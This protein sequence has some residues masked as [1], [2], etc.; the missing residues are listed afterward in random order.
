MKSAVIAMVLL[1]ASYPAAGSYTASLAAAA[2]SVLGKGADF[3]HALVDLNRDSHP[4]AIVLA[5]GPKWCGSGGCVMLIFKGTPRG[6]VLV[7][8][9]TITAPPISLLPSSHL[10]WTDLIVHSNGTGDVVLRFDGS[11]YPHNPSLA[12]AATPQQKRS[13]VEILSQAS[14]QHV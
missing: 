6:Y 10:G 7:S 3:S 14:N 8:R 1:V 12:P 4:D 13:A 9:S 2:V 5:R 11:R